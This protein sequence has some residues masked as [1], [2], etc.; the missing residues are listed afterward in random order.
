[1]VVAVAI[2][3]AAAGLVVLFVM[4]VSLA[5]QTVRVARAVSDFN[6]AMRPALDEIRTATRHAES[7]LQGI[8]KRPPGR[9]ADKPRRG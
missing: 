8:S 6:Q 1:M 9:G 4:V 7:Q 5:R 2:S 3:L